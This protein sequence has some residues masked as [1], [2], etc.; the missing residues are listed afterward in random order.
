MAGARAILP[1]IFFLVNSEI[2]SG[3]VAYL[4]RIEVLVSLG[5]SEITL[6]A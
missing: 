1:L 2:D 5:S 4:E 6:E 3:G